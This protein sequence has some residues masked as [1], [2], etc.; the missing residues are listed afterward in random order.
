MKKLRAQKRPY[1][2]FNTEKV[3]RIC[4]ITNFLILKKSVASPIQY[5]ILIKDVKNI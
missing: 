4:S 1:K 5:D 3:I 2:D